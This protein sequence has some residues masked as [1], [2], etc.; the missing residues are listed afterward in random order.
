MKTRVSKSDAELLLV[1]MGEQLRVS[2]RGVA[3]AMRNLDDALPGFPSR[4]SGAAP[5]AGPGPLRREDDGSDRDEAQLLPVERMATTIDPARQA[6][7]RIDHLLEG[8]RPQITE[9][10]SLVQQWSFDAH[11]SELDLSE[12]HEWCTSCLRLQRCEPRHRG[13]LCRWCGDFLASEG[14]RPSVTLLD[15]HHRGVRITRQMIVADHPARKVRG[16]KST[17][18][19]RV[20]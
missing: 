4:A 5:S 8:L 15:A 13:E 19:R 7:R 10:Y 1:E 14:R 18:K 2:A 20:A 16:P 12:V 17:K 3:R 9:L 6:L 11:Q